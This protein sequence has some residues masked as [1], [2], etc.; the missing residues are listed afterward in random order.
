AQ[1]LME[2]ALKVQAGLGFSGQVRQDFATGKTFSA[3]ALVEFQDARHYKVV[4][5][6]P[7]RIRGVTLWMDMPKVGGY[8]PKDELLVTG[9]ASSAY[10]M[11]PFVYQILNWKELSENW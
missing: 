9:N 1:Q 4:G 2:R 7:E 6:L 3:E 5:L 11:S 8:W 10:V